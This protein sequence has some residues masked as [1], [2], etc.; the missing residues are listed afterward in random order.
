MPKSLV[1]NVK[2]LG[3][4]PKK[5]DKPKLKELGVARLPSREA[6]D[7]LTK[8]AEYKHTI[9]QFGRLTPIGFG[10]PSFGTSKNKKKPGDF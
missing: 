5:P 1:P 9:Q 4:K 3:G 7:F 8:G 10:S 6:L 2:P